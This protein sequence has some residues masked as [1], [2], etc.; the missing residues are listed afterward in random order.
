[1]LNYLFTNTS[2]DVFLFFCTRK[3]LVKFW[4]RLIV[5]NFLLEPTLRVLSLYMKSENAEQVIIHFG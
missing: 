4:V 3:A 1:M 2:L 5:N